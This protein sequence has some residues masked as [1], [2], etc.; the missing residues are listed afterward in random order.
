[1]Y[2]IFIFPNCVQMRLNFFCYPGKYLTTLF[3]S[4]K[5]ISSHYKIKVKKKVTVCT[6][7]FGISSPTIANTNHKLLVRIDTSFLVS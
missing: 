2:A 3:V 6:D 5:K 4:I 1:M 7:K